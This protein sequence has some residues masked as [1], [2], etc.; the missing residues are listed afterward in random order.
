MRNL[1]LEIIGA[2]GC[3]LPAERFQNVI[4]QICLYLTLY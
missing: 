4:K 3:F 2:R 1:K